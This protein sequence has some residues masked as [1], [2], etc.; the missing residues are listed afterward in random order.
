[1]NRGCSSIPI[2]I[3]PFSSESDSTTASSCRLTKERPM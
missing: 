3:H 1:M 2:E